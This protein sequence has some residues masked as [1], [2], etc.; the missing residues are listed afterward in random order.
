[1][2]RI[3]KKIAHLLVS[4]LKEKLGLNII[5]ILSKENG[6]IECN[7][8]RQIIKNNSELFEYCKKHNQLE[9][10]L[11]IQKYKKLELGYY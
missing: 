9:E 5:T 7:H 11:L 6:L 10:F 2:N 8:Q 4:N 3:E 1:M